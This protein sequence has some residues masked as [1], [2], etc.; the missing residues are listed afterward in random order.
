MP[1]DSRLP[2]LDALRAVWMVWMAAFHFAFNLAHFRLI[3]ANFYVDPLWTTQ[4]TLI[5]SGFL[6][7]AGLSQALAHEAGQSAPR[8]W[9]RWAQVAGAA[10]LVSLGSALMFPNSWISFGVLHAFALM[11]PLLRWG[12]GRWPTGC[13]VAL[14]A[15]AWVLPGWVQHP[16]FDTRWTNWV[17][18]VTHKPITEDFVPLLPWL[19]P[20]LLGW[21][22]A[23]QPGL[24]R[25]LA[26]PVPGAGRA[27]AGLGRWPLTFYLLH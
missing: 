10:A 12:L 26:G 22:A 4:R 27:W 6:F 21:V 5:L 25:W 2:R 3:E 23:R 9:R 24:R 18:L 7:W 13:L 8:F 15:L 20:L 16:V 1:H 19:A 14:A 11:L 17:G